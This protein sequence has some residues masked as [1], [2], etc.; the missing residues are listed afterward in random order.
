MRIWQYNAPENI[1]K[2][3]EEATFLFFIIGIDQDIFIVMYNKSTV[4][5]LFNK[6][7]YVCTNLWKVSLM[8]TNIL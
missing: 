1:T 5:E 2:F 3:D 8:A 6:I 7:K 4:I